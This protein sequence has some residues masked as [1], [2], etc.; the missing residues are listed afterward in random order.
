MCMQYTDIEAIYKCF[1]KHQRDDNTKECVFKT[2]SNRVNDR[3][4]NFK[5]L[6]YLSK[7]FGF[8]FLLINT[9]NS[10]TSSG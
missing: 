3:N 6:K 7:M 8:F 9:P 2:E 5:K 10:T 1:E 4:Q